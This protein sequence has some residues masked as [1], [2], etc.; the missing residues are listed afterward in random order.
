MKGKELTNEVE[1]AVVTATRDFRGLHWCKRS[2]AGGGLSQHLVAAWVSTRSNG[3]ERP[4]GE[5][6]CLSI[7][8]PVLVDTWLACG[9]TTKR[10]ATI[11]L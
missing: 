11:H 8:R 2:G 7:I 5:T 6:F 10:F 3:V 4:Y 9:R 1:K